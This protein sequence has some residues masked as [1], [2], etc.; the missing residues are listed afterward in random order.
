MVHY[1]FGWILFPKSDYLFASGVR[2]V[3]CV[4][5]EANYAVYLHHRYK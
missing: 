2:R 3:L 1:T 4:V 5:H